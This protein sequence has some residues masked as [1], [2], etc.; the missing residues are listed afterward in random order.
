M[1]F[2]R[3]KSFTWGQVRSSKE[4]W[5]KSVMGFI[6]YDWTYKQLEIIMLKRATVGIKLRML[7][8]LDL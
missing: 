3:P 5:G 6:N 4:I 2:C 7:L 1:V 8:A